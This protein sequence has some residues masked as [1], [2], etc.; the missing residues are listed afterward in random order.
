MKKLFL[1]SFVILTS[2]FS[3]A[4]DKK[5]KKAQKEFEKFNYTKAVDIYNQTSGLSTEAERTLAES[6]WWKNDFKNAEIHY[7]IVCSRPS[8]T[9]DD[10]WHYSQVLMGN[11]N[12]EEAKKQLA[13]FATLKQ[14]DTRGQAYAKAGDFVNKIQSKKELFSI[15][16]L[17]INS[18]Q[19]DFGTVYYKNQ[20]VFASSREG[21]NPIVRRWNGNQLPFLDVYI[22]DKATNGDLLN[23][24]AFAKG[25]VNKKY[26]EGP[27][28]FS[29]DGNTMA[30]TKNN[31]DGVSKDGVKKLQL[32]ISENKNGEWQTPQA[33]PYNSAEYS[34]GQATFTNDGKTIYFASDMPGGKGGIDIYKSTRENG[35]WTKPENISEINTE[36][37]EMFPFY[38]KDDVLFFSSD[39]KVGLGGLDIFMSKIKNEKAGKAENIGYPVNDSRDDFA[40][41][42]DD[43]MKMGYFSSNR[44]GGKGDD[45]IYSFTLAKPFRFGKIIKGI[46]KDKNGVIVTNAKV[47]LMNGAKQDVTSVN[48]DDKG[49][50]EFT[51]EDEALYNLLG[52]KEKYFDGKNTANT[53]TPEDIIYADLVLEKDPG[54]SLYTLV[55]DK[56]TKQ[57]LEGVKVTM[58][59]NSTSAEE[60]FNTPASGDFLKPLMTAKL[61][62]SLNYTFK[63]EKEGYMTKTVNYKKVLD[64]EGVYNVHTA[65]DMSMD[66]LEVGTDLAKIIDIK[67]IYFD[68]GKYAIRKDAMVELD[69][70]VKVMT[71]YP[72]MVVEL[73]SHTDCR[74]SAASNMKLSDNRA[75]ASAAYIKKKITNPERIYGKGYGETQLLNGCACEGA[76]KSTCTEEEHQKNRRTE[77]KIIKM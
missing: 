35:N 10:V 57:A 70:I 20:V 63:L 26:H 39:G 21:I 25:A 7:A 24:Q 62:D 60:K 33:F 49:N 72:T 28:A 50:Y 27:A 6:Y 3:F 65:L 53:K 17:D 56:K 18:E 43:E 16:N 41:A 11:K 8:K 47:D 44:E 34:V 31:Y 13:E 77:F 2:L 69:K 54:V 22:A 29:R 40:F 15:K 76:T 75:K 58:I 46:T 30:L 71:D 45:D 68:L 42:L 64:V 51:V 14:D 55:T 66:K 19:Q 9:A 38:H 59:N 74:S 32:F 48:S 4:Q 73:G 23:L 5:A 1:V 61:K 52:K 36:G 37:D 12:Y 67:P